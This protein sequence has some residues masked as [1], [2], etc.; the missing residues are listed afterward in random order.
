M[1]KWAV[2]RGSYSSEGKVRRLAVTKST[3]DLGWSASINVKSDPTAETGSLATKV[4]SGL[5]L[6]SHLCGPFQLICTLLRIDSLLHY[7]HGIEAIVRKQHRQLRIVPVQ[8]AEM[9]V[10]WQNTLHAIFACRTVH[11]NV[12]FRYKCDAVAT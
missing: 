5:W 8:D 4:S 2:Y 11:R 3:Q 6:F 9:Y 7:Q 12:N 1:T 10:V